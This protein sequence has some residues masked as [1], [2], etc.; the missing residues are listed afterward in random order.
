MSKNKPV[1]RLHFLSKFNLT[2]REALKSYILYRFKKEK[3]SFESLDI[4]FC[5]DDHLLQL[6]RQFLKHDYYTDILSFPLSGPGQPLVAEI[7]ISIDRVR[8]N[9][10]NLDSSFKMELHRVIFH[11]ILHFCGYKDKSR[12]DIRRMREMEEKWL[13]GYQTKTH[14]T[15]K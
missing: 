9:A 4:V 5:D 3:K 8:D 7:Y 11:G 13:K 15:R 6:N 1:V 2:S 10:K 14:R 12:V